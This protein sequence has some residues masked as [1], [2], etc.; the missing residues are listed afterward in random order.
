ML[1]GMFGFFNLRGVG[2]WEM[3]YHRMGVGRWEMGVGSWELGERGKGKGVDS[4][5]L[6]IHYPLFTKKQPNPVHPLILKS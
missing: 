4:E 6:T 3:L 1:V 2:S 5:W